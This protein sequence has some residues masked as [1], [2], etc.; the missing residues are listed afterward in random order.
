MT[1]IKVGVIGYGYWGPNLARNFYEIP[2]AELIAISDRKDDQLERANSKYPQVTLTKDYT[3]LF[4]MGL[5]AIVVSTPPHTHFEITKDCLAS[6]MHVL[7]EKPF[8]LSFDEGKELVEMA[9]KRGLALMVGHTFEYNSA[10]HQMKDY[11][12]SNGLGNIHYIDTAR[13]N[14]GLYQREIN[15]LWDLAT[16]D[17]SILLYMLEQNP[18]S[19]SAH[20]VSCVSAGVYDVAYIN[21]VFPNDLM[22]Y[23]HVSWLDPC[24]V[25]RV[26]V[27]GSKKMAVYND[28]ENEGKIKIYDKGVDP[29]AYTDSFSEFQYNYRS[30]DITIPSFRFIEPL[31]EEC[32]HFVDSIVNQTEPKSSGRNALRVIKILE[33]V[34]RSLGNGSAQEVIKW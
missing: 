7:V 29:P 28:L 31:R 32:E 15:V 24:K 14:L 12:Q 17:I 19:V 13:L 23:V 33:A 2:S 5:D 34:E 18:I 25:R 27:V 3:E 4:S 16:H 1:P 30:G 22:A 11:I 6:D 20:G 10:V 9:E 8:T 26:T 21:L